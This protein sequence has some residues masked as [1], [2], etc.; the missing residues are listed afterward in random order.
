VKK[1]IM[2]ATIAVLASGCG[3][4]VD[5]AEDDPPGVLE[6]E[7]P[8]AKFYRLDRRVEMVGVNPAADSSGCGLLTDRAYEDLMGAL[9]GLDPDAEYD[10]PECEYSPVSLVHLEG[11]THSPFGCSWYCCHPDLSK[12]ALVYFA[13]GS[14]FDGPDPNIN[15]EI[16][17][18]LEPD[19]PCP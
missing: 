3:P 10:W 13:V 2:L 8:D 11:F 9:E 14:T 6:Y 12:I 19:V 1:K 16:Y 17:V 5:P 7:M 18:A 15:G 4:E